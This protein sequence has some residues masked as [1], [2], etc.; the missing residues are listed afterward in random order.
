MYR[1]KA[2]DRWDTIAYEHY[3]DETQMKALM[4]ANPEYML[5]DVFPEGVILHLPEVSPSV[6]NIELPPWRRL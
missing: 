2:G 5:V 3:R 4:R 1:T 6:I